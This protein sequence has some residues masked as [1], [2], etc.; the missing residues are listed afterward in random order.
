M[1][2]L[3][4]WTIPE[5]HAGVARQ[6]VKAS[7]SMKMDFGKALSALSPA[8]IASP[9]LAIVDV[10]SKHWALVSMTTYTG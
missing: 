8:L 5:R 6:I 4:C 2:F 7:M 3:L 10:R 9:A 1:F